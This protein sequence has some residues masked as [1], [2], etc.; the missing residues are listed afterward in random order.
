ME[1]ERSSDELAP[2]AHRIAAPRDALF[3]EAQLREAPLRDATFR[4]ALEAQNDS[5][6]QTIAVVD[7]LTAMALEGAAV[8]EIA[9]ELAR[10]VE[11][12]V[13]IF[14]ELFR[15]RVEVGAEGELAPPIAPLD[16]PRVEEMVETVRHKRLPIRLRA[17]PNFVVHR[18]CVIAPIASGE[19]V[20]GFLVATT[21][22][23]GHDEDLQLMTIQHATSILALALVQGERD[24]ELRLRYRTDFVESLL[25]SSLPSP[26]AKELARLAGLLPEAAYEAIAIGPADRDAGYEHLFSRLALEL[27]QAGAGFAAVARADHVLVLAPIEETRNTGALERRIAEGVR[28]AVPTIEFVFGA[29][30]VATEPVALH[31]ADVEARRTL[32]VARRLRLVGEVTSH[33][34]LG[35]Q[36]LLLHVPVEE[37]AT[38]TRDVLGPLLSGVPAEQTL[39][40]TLAAYLRANG[41]LRSAAEELLVHSNTISYRLRRIEELTGLELARSTDR[42]LAAVAVEALRALP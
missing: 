38:F 40:D 42:M 11:A 16:D 37:L 26:K 29:S 18:D 20:L 21:G 12:Q 8:E 22:A 39:L 3:R 23:D 27:Q 7:R 28:R 6:R 13:L 33:D 30:R 24:E 9:S 2:A 25:V 5:L 36:R 15:P 41:N 34:S 35:I 31:L 17:L 4:G 32:E 1:R 19:R 14:D 10:S